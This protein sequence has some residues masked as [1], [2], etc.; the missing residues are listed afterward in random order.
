MLFKIYPNPPKNYFIIDNTNTNIA[1]T[2][3]EI[4]TITGNVILTDFEFFDNKKYDIS[5]YKKGVYFV[6]LIS[7]NGF[8]IEKLT[9]Y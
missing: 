5:N 9:I 2:E 4:Y 6:K 1:I 8:R 3:V 7:D